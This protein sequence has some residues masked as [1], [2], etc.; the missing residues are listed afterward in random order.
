[1]RIILIYPHDSFLVSGHNR[2]LAI[3]KE[4]VGT[5]H[6]DAAY[7]FGKQREFI[8]IFLG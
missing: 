5:G 4:E 3:G 1:M 6:T 2:Q 7:I 8:G